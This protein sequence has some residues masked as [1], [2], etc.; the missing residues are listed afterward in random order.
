MLQVPDPHGH[1]MIDICSSGPSNEILLGEDRT[2]SSSVDTAAHLWLRRALACQNI[3]FA[4][5]QA[6]SPVYGEREV[7]GLWWEEA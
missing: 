6:R 4:E 1:C 3:Y 7:D 2:G 5:L